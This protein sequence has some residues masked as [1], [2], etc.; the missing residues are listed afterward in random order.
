MFM[1]QLSEADP[2]ESP[3]GSLEQPDASGVQNSISGQPV[4]PSVGTPPIC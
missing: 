2:K 4:T 1:P 3:E